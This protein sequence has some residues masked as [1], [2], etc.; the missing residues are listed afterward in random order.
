MRLNAE[1]L[2]LTDSQIGKAFEDRNVYLLEKETIFVM[3]NIAFNIAEAYPGI[4]QSV[5]PTLVQIRKEPDFIFTEKYLSSLRSLLL[6]SE[7]MFQERMDLTELK[8]SFD[9]WFYEVTAG[10]FLVYD[11]RPVHL[12]SVT[13]AAKALGVTRQTIYKY[14]E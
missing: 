11:Y 10:G 4:L 6:L 2:S 9:S 12:L 8:L 7:T 3:Q 1:V 14:M 5:K 13:Q